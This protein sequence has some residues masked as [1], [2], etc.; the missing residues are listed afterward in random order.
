MTPDVVHCGATPALFGLLG[1]LAVELTQSWRAIVKPEV[2]LLKHGGLIGCALLFGML[3]YLNNWAH[4]GGLLF[5]GLAGFVFLPWEAFD[6]F[7]RARKRLFGIVAI[8][9]LVMLF[10][11]FFSLF[12][13]A[14]RVDCPA[15]DK[16][17]CLNLVAAFCEDGALT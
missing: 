6:F 9:G 13:S 16:F 4:M 3:P 5:G 12:F 15:C 8:A 17:N 7:D 14:V 2:Q 11:I 1:C 10:A